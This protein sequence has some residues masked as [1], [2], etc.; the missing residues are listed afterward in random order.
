MTAKKFYKF[1]KHIHMIQCKQNNTQHYPKVCLLS[2]VLALFMFYLSV[3]SLYFTTTGRSR[4]KV[5]IIKCWNYYN[6]TTQIN[7]ISE[8]SYQQTQ[9]SQLCTPAHLPPHESGKQRL[10]DHSYPCLP[11]HVYLFFLVTNTL[12]YKLC[13][14]FRVLSFL[15]WTVLCLNQA[16]LSHWSLQ[17]YWIDH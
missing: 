17:T 8:N 15:N 5:V 9:K 16:V 14:L 2:W 10:D 12:N 11:R 4:I 1:K 3:L 7:L 6:K 13:T